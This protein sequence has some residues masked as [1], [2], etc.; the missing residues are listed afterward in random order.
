ME[1]HFDMEKTIST[2]RVPRWGFGHVTNKESTITL[3]RFNMDPGRN[4]T[5]APHVR[6]IGQLQQSTNEHL[7]NADNEVQ[8][9]SPEQKLE[10]AW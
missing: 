10:T 5:V 7:A 1:Y 2:C 4:A 9:G 8:D 6:Q 3:A